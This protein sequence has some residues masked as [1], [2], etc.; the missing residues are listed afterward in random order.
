MR[1]WHWFSNSCRNTCCWEMCV[2]LSVHVGCMFWPEVVCLGRIRV[3]VAPLGR[4]LQ[5]IGFKPTPQKPSLCLLGNLVIYLQQTTVCVSSLQK[6]VVSVRGS[7]RAEGVWQ[8]RRN[9]LLVNMEM[10]SWIWFSLTAPPFG[11]SGL[12]QL[13]SLEIKCFNH[14]LATHTT[15]LW[16][17]GQYFSLGATVW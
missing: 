14:G 9:P 1:R 3:E 4:G 2:V 16:G 6:E 8:D 10:P 7:Q 17:Q 12:L 13:K 11:H 15:K 5:C